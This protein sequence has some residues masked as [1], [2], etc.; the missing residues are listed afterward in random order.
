MYT[1]GAIQKWSSY[2]HD[3]YSVVSLS[4]PSHFAALR[5]E[6]DYA[7]PMLQCLTVT[8]ISSQQL[9][10]LIHIL[11]S[12]NLLHNLV[13][14]IHIITKNKLNGWFSLGHR[15]DTVWVSH[16]ITIGLCVCVLLVLI[17]ML[18]S[19]VVTDG[20]TLWNTKE[21]EKTICYIIY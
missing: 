21:S 19:F 3:R 1:G 9:S 14:F 20:Y 17:L 11:V 12:C 6:M 2:W 15:S 18:M 13:N 10:S 7:E 8:L 16:L 4:L 5:N